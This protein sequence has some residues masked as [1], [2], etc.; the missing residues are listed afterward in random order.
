MTVNWQPRR[1]GPIIDDIQIAH[2][3]ARGILILPVRGEAVEPVSS[4]LPVM[5]V[6][7]IEDV[8]KLSNLDIDTAP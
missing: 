7:G 3:G 4:E 5:S 1:E 6:S 8:P 2:D